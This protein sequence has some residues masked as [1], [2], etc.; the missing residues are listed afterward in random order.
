MDLPTVTIYLAYSD[1]SFPLFVR[2]RLVNANPHDLVRTHRMVSAYEQVSRPT[3]INIAVIPH[4]VRHVMGEFFFDQSP[5]TWQRYFVM[6]GFVDPL[7]SAAVGIEL[8]SLDIAYESDQIEGLAHISDLHQTQA[9]RQDYSV[10]TVQELGLVAKAAPLHRG[11]GF[12]N[13]RKRCNYGASAVHSDVTRDVGR[14]SVGKAGAARVY[15]NHPVVHRHVVRPEAQSIWVLP[16]RATDGS[17]YPPHG[18]RIGV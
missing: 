6:H 9:I 10:V 18:L 3:G 11:Y 12:E 1:Q 4:H 16:K 13:Q 7:A 17:V 8:M 14:A 2:D 15:V 5:A